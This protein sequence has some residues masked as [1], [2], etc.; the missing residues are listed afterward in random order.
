MPAM[1]SPTHPSVLTVCVTGAAGQISYSLL[2]ILANGHVFGINQPIA[3]RLLEITPALP[4]LSGVSMELIDGS[5][6]LLRSVVETDDPAHAF[7][8]ADVAVLVGAFP[9]KHGMER[10]DL[11]AK[12]VPI[13]QKQAY[14]LNQFASP[15]VKVLVVGNPA[16][17]NALILSK[18]APNIPPTNVSALTRLDHNR[19]LAQV[20]TRLDVPIHSVDGVCIWGNHSSTQYPDV[21]RAS[22]HGHPVL[23]KLGGLERVAEDFIPTIQKRGAAIIKARGLSSAMSAANAI[24]DHLRSWICGDDRIV[25][26]AVHADGSYGI[27]EGVFFSYPVRCLGDGDYEIVRGID[28]D[29]FSRKY[30]DATA[31]ELYAERDEAL[32]LLI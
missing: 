3:L 7:K 31:E 4:A 27:K 15:D 10:K 25:S 26:M 1:T 11:L 17:T 5:Y 18:F 2:P 14:A 28:L 20:A 16:N 6:P 24:A 23:D 22:V 12:N 19:A 9:R 30:I 32:S 8:G 21:V 29:H 13:F